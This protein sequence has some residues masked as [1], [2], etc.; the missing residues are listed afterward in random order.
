MSQ[1]PQFAGSL[2]RSTQLVPQASFPDGQ[3]QFPDVH[4]EPVSGQLASVWHCTQLC[5]VVSQ[6]GLETGQSPLPTHATHWWVA[7]KQAGV[8]GVAEQ[9]VALRQETQ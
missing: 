4:V 1:A 5:A 6:Y 2:V 3:A 8:A 9:S 7:V